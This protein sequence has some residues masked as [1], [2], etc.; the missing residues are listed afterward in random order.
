MSIQMAYIGSG[1]EQSTVLH[2]KQIKILDL[3]LLNTPINKNGQIS[4][5]NIACCTVNIP[6]KSGN[7]TSEFLTLNYI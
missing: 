4:P 2:S 1:K 6:S 3:L 7:T 5:I